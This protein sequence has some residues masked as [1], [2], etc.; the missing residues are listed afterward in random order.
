MIEDWTTAME[1]KCPFLQQYSTFSSAVITEISV[2]FS[3]S[4]LEH[5]RSVW[6]VALNS[7]TRCGQCRQRPVISLADKQ[8]P[9]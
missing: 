5:T 2:E 4:A 3:L 9:F 1:A 8:E 6:I 7:I